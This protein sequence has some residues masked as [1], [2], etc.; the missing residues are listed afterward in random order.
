MAETKAERRESWKQRTTESATALRKAKA[1]VTTG[2]KRSIPLS[3]KTPSEISAAAGGVNGAPM[4][5]EQAARLDMLIA[6]HEARTRDTPRG[7]GGMVTAPTRREQELDNKRS[8]Y[9]APMGP[10]QAARLDMLIAQ[11]EARVRTTGP[12]Y[13]TEGISAYTSVPTER[14]TPSPYKPG[15]RPEDVEYGKRPKFDQIQIHDVM[16]EK[17]RQLDDLLGERRVKADVALSGRLP[18]ISTE[19]DFFQKK[20]E[21]FKETPI[22]TVRDIGVDASMLIG[23][24]YIVGGITK[25]GILGT[26]GAVR[27]GAK[28]TA[29]KI[30][31]TDVGK[32]IQKAVMGTEKVIEPSVGL[33][34]AYAG[35]QDIR[36]TP[37]E[38]LPHKLYEY[39][40]GFA[41]AAKGYRAPE[42]MI[43]IVRVRGKKEIPVEAV[44]E[45]QIL[46]GAEPFPFV[47][48]GETVP[49]L[50]AR[51]E[52]P[53]YKLPTETPGMPQ[54]WHATAKP[55]PKEVV[56]EGG[57]VRPSDLPGLY[58]APSVSPHFLRTGQIKTKDA[59]KLS[60]WE[61]I[62]GGGE[63]LTP[64]LLSVEVPGISRIPL[65]YRPSLEASKKYV[66][67]REKAEAIITRDVELAQLGRGRVEAEVVVPPATKLIRVG[68]D[69]YIRVGDRKVPIDKYIAEMHI[70]G[71]KKQSEIVAYEPTPRA[72]ATPGPPYYLPKAKKRSPYYRGDTKPST[73]L[74][75]AESDYVPTPKREYA[76]VGVSEYTPAPSPDIPISIRDYVPPPPSESIAPYVPEYRPPPPKESVIPYIP[77][78]APPPTITKL[79]TRPDEKMGFVRKDRL[80]PGYAWQLANPIATLEQLLGV[81]KTTKKKRTN[82][83]SRKTT[84]KTRKGGLKR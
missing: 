7:A 6:Q 45:P 55:F 49:E 67:T 20:Y 33:G 18:D 9:V 72:R 73:S 39:G 34:F 36:A 64:T 69:Y 30:P 37:K 62:F 74:I 48:K 31:D 52:S 78:Y 8:M 47:K 41:G 12:S 76:A 42:K 65:K 60:S 35:Y 5:P 68:T 28:K 59:P 15:T 83:T 71:R 40:L 50:M 21:G 29:K 75:G 53:E 44:V 84:K 16:G 54:V 1:T 24:S 23:G 11:H 4:G 46:S 80:M 17:L 79:K 2:G 51:F 58:G 66:S 10:E 82:R 14:Y 38:E 63:S 19:S 70:K 32:L 81:Q 77:E 3:A 43:D 22:T 25:L 61:R 13:T 57:T 56:I 26:R 27:Y